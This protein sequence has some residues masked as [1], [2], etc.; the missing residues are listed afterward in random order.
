MLVDRITGRSREVDVCVR[1]VLATQQVV[2][3][4]EC[5]DR[6]RPADVTWVDE[7]HTKHSRLATNLLILASH[8]SFTA[9]A[10]R[11]A[12]GYG[13]RHVAVDD[14]ASSAEGRLFPTT[15]SLWGKT[16]NVAIE[17]VRITAEI[18][19][20]MSTETFNAEPDT[21]LYLSDGMPLCSASEMAHG[22]ANLEQI[23][24]QIGSEAAPEHKYVQFGWDRHECD[25]KRICVQKLEP[26]E[27]RPIERFNVVGKCE[28]TINEFPLRHGVYGP[29]RVA[30]GK[31][32]M[33]GA[34]MMVVATSDANGHLKI[35]L[36]RSTDRVSGD[37]S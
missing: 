24:R 16:W 30:W 25:G 5:R 28:V 15:S 23:V 9:E 31:G 34:T 36:R 35:S 11:V 20:A 32:T 26:M 13:I 8:S 14:V 21:A 10:I 27:Y 17:R 33:L 4:I 22:L 2:V 29:V 3:S 12:D 1:G 7:M 19:G 6:T 18:P 37:D